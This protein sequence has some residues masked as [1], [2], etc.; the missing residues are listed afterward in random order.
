MTSLIP[1]L[2]AITAAYLIGGIPFGVLIARSKGI[3]IRQHGS[4]NIGATNVWRVLGKKH[5]LLCF[6]LDFLKG[7]GPVLV[8]GIIFNTL[9][10]ESLPAHT[11]WL[12]LGVAVASVVGHMHSPFL[13]FAGGKGVATGFGAMVAVWPHITAAALIA[14][15][16]WIITLKIWKMVSISSCL[17]AIA[18]PLAILLLSTLARWPADPVT[19]WPYIALTTLVALLVIYKHRANLARV[20]AGTERRIG[21]PGSPGTSPPAPP[22]PSG[23]PAPRP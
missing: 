3:D 15:A 18:M 8:A 7:A 2:I 21:T 14:L 20:R 22:T 6:T 17:A 19:A 4:K 12:W 1:W 16:V 23:T 5:G 10:A 11:S 9:G 13:G